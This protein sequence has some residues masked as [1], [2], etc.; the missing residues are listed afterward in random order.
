MIF[1]K[2]YANGCSFTCAGGLHW[3]RVKKVYK[4][5]LN[6]DIKNHIDY[7]YPN[8]LAKKL[9]IDII[10][11]AVPGASIQRVVRT[12]YDYIFKNIN[13]LKNTLLIIEV[14]LCWRDE[15]YSNELKRMIN[16][17]AGNIGDVNDPTDLANGFDK[18][19][20]K[21]IHKDI[22]NYFYNFVDVDLDMLKFTLSLMGLISYIKLNELNY[23]LIDSGLFNK[24]NKDNDLT[25]D[26]NYVWFENRQMCE[27]ITKNSLLIT[28]E[29]KGEVT[30]GHAGIYGNKSIA[31]QLYYIITK[32]KKII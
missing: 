22:T 26:Y 21:K 31:E 18:D 23:L 28:N 25:N 24:F 14:P 29:T 15:F 11:D 10:N 30:D 8:V 9:G 12:T 2:I 3:D 27:W 32:E 6:I 13:N 4:E 7:A 20:I 5:K 1:E 17:T 19:D 16:I